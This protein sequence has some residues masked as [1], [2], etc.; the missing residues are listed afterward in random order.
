VWRGVAES[1]EV[2]DTLKDGPGRYSCDLMGKSSRPQFVLATWDVSSNV[3][4]SA[5]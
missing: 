1:S 4:V 3:C 2:A 5:A